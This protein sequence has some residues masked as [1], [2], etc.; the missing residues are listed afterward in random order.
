MDAPSNKNRRHFPVSITLIVLIIVVIAYL[1]L[2]D[3]EKTFEKGVKQIK[4][5]SQVRPVDVPESSVPMQIIDDQVKKLTSV[6]VESTFLKLYENDDKNL[7]TC[8]TSIWK[9][10]EKTNDHEEFK[11]LNFTETLNS[12][13]HNCLFKLESQRYAWDSI[14]KEDLPYKVAIS[15]SLERPIIFYLNFYRKVFNSRDQTLT[16]LSNL[17]SFLKLNLFQIPPHQTAD[18]YAWTTIFEEFLSFCG[19]ELTEGKQLVKDLDR[20]SSDHFDVSTLNGKEEQ[21]SKMNDYLRSEKKMI[22]QYQQQ[23]QDLFTKYEKELIE[24]GSNK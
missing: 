16:H 22:K 6:D 24:C 3:N 17:V 20:D 9:T 4:T 11:V 14:E 10:V 2:R 23:L 19:Y 7:K 12:M 18:I 21:N 15:H 8:N 1:F 5:K 13:I